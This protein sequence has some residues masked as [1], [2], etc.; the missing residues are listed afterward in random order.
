MVPLTKSSFTTHFV[1]DCHAGQSTGASFENEE[2][3]EGLYLWICFSQGRA[4]LK[5]KQNRFICV[6]LQQME[7]KNHRFLGSTLIV[8]PAQVCLSTTGSLLVTGGGS[9]TSSGA[10]SSQRCG[11]F[12]GSPDRFL[13]QMIQFSLIDSVTLDPHLKNNEL[14]YNMIRLIINTNFINIQAGSSLPLIGESHIGQIFLDFQGLPE[15]LIK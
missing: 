2:H 7:P 6:E 14:I 5:A 11:S 8:P 13:L 12:S 15:C 9:I 3:R 4:V 10:R 1:C